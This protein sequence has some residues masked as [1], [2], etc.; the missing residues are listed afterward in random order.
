MIVFLPN[1]QS[2]LSNFQQLL[3]IQ[4]WQEW[5]SQFSKMQGY[6][7]LPRFK[8]GYEDGLIDVFKALGM[9]ESF[10]SHANYQ[11]MCDDPVSI[12]DIRHKAFIDVNEEGTEASGATS[13]FI[14]RTIGGQKFFRM[15]INRPFFSAIQDN[16]T[17]VIL[18]M[19]AIW[20]PN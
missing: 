17:G 6:L 7:V 19:G 2:S 3:N 10:S 13:V 9:N 1:E 8:V 18:F 4:K 16:Q 11:R 20:E 5:K 12:S 14:Q 15:V